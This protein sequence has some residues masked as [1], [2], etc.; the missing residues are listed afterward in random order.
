MGIHRAIQIS[1]FLIM[2]L[3]FLKPNF[4]VILKSS[5][6]SS[7]QFSKTHCYQQRLP[8]HALWLCRDLS[9][10]HGAAL[11]NWAA[12]V[13]RAGSQGEGTRVGGWDHLPNLSSVTD[14]P[15]D[16]GWDTPVSLFP[17]FPFACLNYLDYKT[18][19]TRSVCSC[20]TVQPST[21]LVSAESWRYCHNADKMQSFQ[22]PGK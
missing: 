2:L 12:F 16:L 15:C 8:L 1:Y 17:L 9:L 20:G 11:T 6:C 18:C 19:A 3:Y 22:H 7:L 14:Q 21:S 10:L 5:L 13:S 4:R